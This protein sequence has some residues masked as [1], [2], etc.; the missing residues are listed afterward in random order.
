MCR[1]CVGK[2]FVESDV[3]HDDEMAE[4]IL[5]GRYI[6]LER[7]WAIPGQ[8]YGRLVAFRSRGNR[9]GAITKSPTVWRCNLGYLERGMY[10]FDWWEAVRDLVAA[11]FDEADAHIDR[12]LIESDAEQSLAAES[13]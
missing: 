12:F 3:P 10:G 2:V 4:G 11:D 13:R 8:W 5:E 9:F 6:F 7:A 1:F